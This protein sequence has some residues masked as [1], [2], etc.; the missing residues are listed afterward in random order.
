[1]NTPDQLQTHHRLYVAAE[2]E[3]TAEA[4]TAV[5]N[6]LSSLESGEVRAARRSETGEWQVVPEVKEGILLAFRVGRLAVFPEPDVPMTFSDKSTFRPRPLPLAFRNIRLV[7]GGSSVRRGAY[8]GR[9]V[10]CMPPMFVNVGAWIGE[11]TMIDSHALVGSCAQI[12]RGVH[13]SAA[14]Q[15]GGVLEPIGMRPVIIEDGVLVGGNCGVYEGTLVRERTMRERVFAHKPSPRRRASTT[16]SSSGSFARPTMR[17][18]R[19]PRARS[20]CRERGPSRAPTSRRST[21]C[22]S[23]RR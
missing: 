22:R 4:L 13:L 19:S 5:E 3:P 18:S 6:L 9:D 16:S 15:I 14:A 1:M 10:A 2:R 20:W 8:L 12:G 21:G 7:P 11:G 23:A 17:R